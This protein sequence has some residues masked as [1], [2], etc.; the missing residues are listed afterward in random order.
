MKFIPHVDWS[1]VSSLNVPSVDL[2]EHGPAQ[3]Y[4]EANILS[5]K[6]AFSFFCTNL[7]K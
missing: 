6:G 7:F 4:L 2:G 5:V 1:H 3:G